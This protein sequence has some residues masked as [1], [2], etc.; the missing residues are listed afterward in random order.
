MEYWLVSKASLKMWNTGSV[1]PCV[2]ALMFFGLLVIGL[3]G[4]TGMMVV[5]SFMRQLGCG[6]GGGG[7]GGEVLGG[8]GG[9][10]GELLG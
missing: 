9:G 10:A 3:T 5:V 1:A 6:L 2:I 8:G 4:L 7:G